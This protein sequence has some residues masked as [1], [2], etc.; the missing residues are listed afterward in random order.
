MQITNLE[1]K[2]FSFSIIASFTKKLN[3]N[4]IIN[5]LGGIIILGKIISIKLLNNEIEENL[6][7]TNISG[8]YF[9]KRFCW[10]TNYAVR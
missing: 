4:K 8:R 7:A 1:L 5:K 9:I 6:K 3:L 2:N 10:T